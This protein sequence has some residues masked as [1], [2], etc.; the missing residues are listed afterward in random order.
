MYYENFDQKSGALIKSLDIA[1]G[2]RFEWLITPKQV[3][4]TYY[5]R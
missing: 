1:N 3:H 2:T 4:A 5:M